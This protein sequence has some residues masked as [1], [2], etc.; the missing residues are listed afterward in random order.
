MRDAA[1][2]ATL[3]AL[4]SWLAAYV[5]EPLFEAGY[6]F[7]LDALAKFFLTGAVALV[8]TD[9]LFRIIACSLFMLACSNLSDELFFDNTTTGW[10]EYV[11]G[12]IVIAYAVYKSLKLY[13]SST[14]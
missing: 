14:Q 7:T 13:G 12:M 3:L 10:N 8:A 9:Q 6:W 4:I 2:I 11:F 5:G 1:R